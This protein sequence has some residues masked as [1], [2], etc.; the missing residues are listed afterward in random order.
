MTINS[1]KNNKN[2]K[3]YPT[4]DILLN[5]IWFRKFS[6]R[7][8]LYIYYRQKEFALKFRGTALICEMKKNLKK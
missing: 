7:E 8:K 5:I 6:L 3:K 1:K 4:D 2:K